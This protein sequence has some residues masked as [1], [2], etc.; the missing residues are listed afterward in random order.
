[1]AEVHGI[2]AWIVAVAAGA[3]VVASV[4]MAVGS[5]RSRLW[6][7]RT[8]LALL[9]AAIAAASGGIVVA[10]TAGPPRDPLHLVYG[11]AVLVVPVVGR[12]VARGAEPRRLGRMMAVVAVVT[13][14]VALRAI[15]TGG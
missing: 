10:A 11:A 8:I 14:G 2:L 6:L 3:L 5:A 7:D 15:T 4:A 1:M 13:A 9:V 12:Y